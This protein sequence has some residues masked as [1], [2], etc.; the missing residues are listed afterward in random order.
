[1]NQGKLLGG[2]LI[3]A[4]VVGWLVMVAFLFVQWSTR[5]VTLSGA[6]LGMLLATLCFAVPLAGG[7]AYLLV[8][9]RKE[10]QEMARAR[11]ERDLLN[12]VLTQGRVTFADAAITL[13]IPRD[14][15]AALV[16]S[17]VGK[18]LFS[19][20][21]HWEKGI[22]YS[23]ELAGLVQ[24]RRC[25]NCGGE[26]EIAGRGLLVCPWCGAEIFIHRDPN[27]ASPGQQ[28]GPVRT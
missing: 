23:Q 10:A 1:M 14:Q 5:E 7:G 27:T 13:N 19:G 9:G 26:I 4:A 6:F 22:L 16:R 24:S 28:G 2:L 15:V 21:V 17:L 20:A 25:P 8:Q 11:L 18:G 12:M 3:A